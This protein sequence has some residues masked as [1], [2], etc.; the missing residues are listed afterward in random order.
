[1]TNQTLWNKIIEPFRNAFL[2]VEYYFAKRW[3]DRN[4]GKQDY[5]GEYISDLLHERDDSSKTRPE[6]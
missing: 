4:F 2:G 6:Q 5:W 3:L 1:M